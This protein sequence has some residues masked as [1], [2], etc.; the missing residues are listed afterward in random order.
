M[1]Q[2]QP[3]RNGL[4]WIGTLA[5]AGLG[6]PPIVEKLVVSGQS[7]GLFCGD[8]LLQQTDGSVYV[9]TAGTAAAFVMQSCSNY[10]G[11]DSIPRK[12]QYLPAG[13][14]YTG[15]QDFTNPFASRVLV[16]PLDTNQLFEI[17]VPTGA[18]SAA[19]AEAL[20]GQ[21]VNLLWSTGGSTLTGWS[22]VTTDTVA[23]FAGSGTQ[24]DVQLRRI[25]RYGFNG[26][27][28]DPTQAFWTGIFSY[29]RITTLG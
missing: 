6:T 1:S 5:A 12:G 23:N 24:A 9:T 18:A 29:N 11:P 16:I 21:A 27:P 8:A 17:V 14:T 3:R 22:G 15:N 19:A 10:L 20:V 4:R 7:A 13:T 25:P 2:Q 26:L 28:N